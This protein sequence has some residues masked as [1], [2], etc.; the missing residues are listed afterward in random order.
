[1]FSLI[2]KFRFQVLVFF[3]SAD[4]LFSASLASVLEPIAFEKPYIINEGSQK[5]EEESRACSTNLKEIQEENVKD[6]TVLTLDTFISALESTLLEHYHIDGNLRLTFLSSWPHITV[7]NHDWSIQLLESPRALSKR[8]LISL[9]ILNKGIPIGP[10]R[11]AVSCELF[12]ECYVSK[13]II[14]GKSKLLKDDFEI[15]PIDVLAYKQSIV[16]AG[17]D[18]TEYEISQSMAAQQPLFWRSIS[19]KPMVKKGK[20]VN[21]IAKDGLLSIAMKAEVLTSGFLGDFITLRNLQSKK[22]FQGR[23]KNENTVEVYF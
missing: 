11:F 9:N 17:V 20:V 23:I 4:L 5:I 19:K 2:L 13:E 3:F 21:A 8:T 22:E 7:D 16:D 15:H 10:F 6:K 12:K 18:L 1:M 14:Y